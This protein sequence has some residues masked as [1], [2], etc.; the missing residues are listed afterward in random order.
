MH[1]LNWTEK[2]ETKVMMKDILRKI[3]FVFVT[4]LAGGPMVD[5]EARGISATN[6]APDAAMQVG[7]SQLSFSDDFDVNPLVSGWYNNLWFSKEA[8]ISQIQVKDGILRL[9][10]GVS[11][12]T[13]PRNGAPGRTFKFG[14]FEAR[15][16]FR[17]D[18][19]NFPAFWLFSREHASDPRNVR[20]CELDIF[21]L[22]GADAYVGTVHD[23]LNFKSAKNSNNYHKLDKRIDFEAWNTYGVLWTEDN[24]SWFLNGKL[25]MQAQ[26]PKVCR[27]QDMF[28]ILS[29]QS[30]SKVN[31]NLLFVDWVKVWTK[32]Q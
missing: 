4:L 7:F 22:F 10:S 2:A 11:I 26:T 19:D 24:I 5:S 18:P 32:K 6:S 30:H 1:E 3:I 12:T 16:K 31:G 28:L 25:M 9:S 15:M 14:Y 29:S 17:P 20:W 21:E 8:P 27:E 23:W 13:L